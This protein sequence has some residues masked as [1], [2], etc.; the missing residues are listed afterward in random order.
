DWSDVCGEYERGGGKHDTYSFIPVYGSLLTYY[1]SWKGEYRSLDAVAGTFY[2]KCFETKPG[3]SLNWLNRH[4]LDNDK[5]YAFEISLNNTANT[6]VADGK[7]TDGAPYVILYK[8]SDVNP[9]TNGIVGT[10][11]GTPTVVLGAN[12]TNAASYATVLAVNPATDG[13]TWGGAPLANTLNAPGRTGYIVAVAINTATDEIVAITVSDKIDR[14][15]TATATVFDDATPSGTI[16]SIA[17]TYTKGVGKTITGITKIEWKV[18]FDAGGDT[19]FKPLTSSAY[20]SF[21]STTV[22]ITLGGMAEITTPDYGYDLVAD[23]EITFKVTFNNGEV[24]TFVY[25]LID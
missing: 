20:Y 24:V 8:W 22:N 19:P 17:A 2:S 4:W 6:Y 16:T 10:K 21:T 15:A 11:I 3:A 5:H 13:T 18:D 1:D 14:A 25:T 12:I 9:N 23:D 7:Y